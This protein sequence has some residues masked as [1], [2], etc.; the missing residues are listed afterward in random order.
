VLSLREI[1]AHGIGSGPFFT[2]VSEGGFADNEVC[3][4][5]LEYGGYVLWSALPPRFDDEIGGSAEVVLERV[6][7]LGQFALS[8]SCDAQD[9]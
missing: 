3:G 2:D 5:V 4:N 8:S 7:C 1:N 6:G 9:R